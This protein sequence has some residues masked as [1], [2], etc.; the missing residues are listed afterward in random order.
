[1]TPRCAQALLVKG[2]ESSKTEGQICPGQVCL[3]STEMLTVAGHGGRVGWYM[4]G[5]VENRACRG[6]QDTERKSTGK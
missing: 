2:K 3:G 5:G 4:G 6:R 1:M